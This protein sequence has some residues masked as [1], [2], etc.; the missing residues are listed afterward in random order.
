MGANVG[1]SVT[2]MLVSLAHMGS[3]EELERAFAGSSIYYLFNI[4]TCIVLLP[5]EVGT[6]YLYVLT[7]AMLPQSVGDGDTWKSKPAQRTVSECHHS[8]LFR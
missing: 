8:W 1:T 7:K 2:S 4:F 5:I 3:G 6:G